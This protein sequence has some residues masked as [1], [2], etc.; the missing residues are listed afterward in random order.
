M[1]CRCACRWAFTFCVAWVGGSPWASLGAAFLL[2]GVLSQCPVGLTERRRW[3]W[4]RR[5]VAQH[6]GSSALWRRRRRRRRLVGRRLLRCRRGCV[7][8]HWGSLL[9]LG[10]LLPKHL[11]CW[12]NGLCHRPWYGC[13]ASRWGSRMV[14]CS[15]QLEH[16]WQNCSWQWALLAEIECA[17][18]MRARW[19]MLVPDCWMPWSP[20]R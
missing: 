12:Q 9:V 16:R 1:V 7:A 6:E 13:F 11:Q 19:R 8:G 18:S 15:S 5:P 20:Q 17:P 4:R 2:V 3:R 10:Q 14:H